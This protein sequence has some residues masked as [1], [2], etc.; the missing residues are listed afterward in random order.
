[1]A[2][3]WLAQRLTLGGPMCCA[4]KII[5]PRR[6][7]EPGYRRM[8]L[9]E[10]RLALSL[11]GHGNVVS[12]FDVGEC[13][14][15]L[16]LAMER[17]DGVTLSELARRIDGPWPV[18]HAVHVVAAVLRALCHLHDYAVG[19]QPRGVVHRDVTPHNVMITS[20]GEVKLTDFGIAQRADAT[21]SLA[22]ALGKLAYVPREQLE[23]EPDQR[24]DLY[25]AGALLYELLDGRRFRWHCADEDAL[26]QEIYRDRVPTLSRTDI[27]PPVLAVLRGLLQPDRAQ[28]IGSATAALRG[29]EAWS[30]FGGAQSELEAE[31]LRVVGPPRSGRTEL[32]HAH[33][34]SDVP[35][36]RATASSTSATQA[37]A[38]APGTPVSVA[39]FERRATTARTRA[40]V[41]QRTTAA[42]RAGVEPRTPPTGRADHAPTRRLPAHAVDR[43]DLMEG[44]VTRRH[45]VARE[46]DIPTARRAA[47]LAVTAPQPSRRAPWAADTDPLAPQTS[48]PGS[49]VPWVRHRPTVDDEAEDEDAA[50]AIAP[51]RRQ[52]AALHRAASG[53]RAR[54]A[55]GEIVAGEIV[56]ED[57]GVPVWRVGSH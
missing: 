21:P 8:F 48:E 4:V 55:T 25:G 9:R 10:G 40:N 6:A 31:Y 11:C 16:F 52:S 38:A 34:P 27:P 51:R 3:V 30:G 49:G 47:D 23:G 46:A 53:Y 26:F 43:G 1:M 35:R 54:A 32:Q 56:A 24:S 50:D 19:G 41:P 57:R 12:V 20:R 29:L 22:R 17:I 18:A 36:A 45:P 42:T 39:A 44:M 15:Q 37:A 5:H 13:D 33:V 7:A 2:Q 14:G 28:R